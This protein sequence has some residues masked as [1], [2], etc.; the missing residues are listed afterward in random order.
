ML[1]GLIFPIR[2]KSVCVCVCECVTKHITLFPWDQDGR[3]RKEIPSD[4]CLTVLRKTWRHKQGCTEIVISSYKQDS[5]H[6]YDTTTKSSA[7]LKRCGFWE[8]MDTM[9]EGKQKEE[10]FNYVF[11]FMSKWK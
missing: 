10:I 9:F 3:K 2:L 7:H 1:M 6:I 8:V 5:C 4:S 11:Q